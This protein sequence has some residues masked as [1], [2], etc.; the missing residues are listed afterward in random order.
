M[1]SVSIVNNLIAKARR[2]LS[3]AVSIQDEDIKEPTRLAETIRQMMLR[4]NKLEAQQ[5]P[6]A[7]E[8]ELVVGTAGALS[9]LPHNFNTAVRWWVTSWLQASGVAYPVS[10]PSLAEDS[11]STAN[12]LFLRSY[13]AGRA[14]VRVEPSQAYLDPGVIVTASPPGPASG[15]PTGTGFYHTSSGV[16]D[17]ASKKVD[18]AAAAD[19]TGTLAVG[20][21]GTG[22]TS[23]GTGVATWLGTPSSANLAAALT[24]ETGTGVAVFSTTPTFS[25]SVKLNNPGGTFA[26]TIVGGALASAQT[27]TLPLL[28]GADTFVTEAF[29][30]TLT[31]KTMSGSSNTFT[32]ISLTTAV[33]GTL[34]VANG[35]T[36]ITSFGTGVATWLGTPSGANL[37]SA[38]TT[39]LP[40]SKSTA[41]V[42]R[43]VFSSRPSAGTAGRLYMVT[44]GPLSFYDDGAAW[45]PFLA[46]AHLTST[47]AVSTL[48][49]IN[50]GG[51]STT[52]SDSLGGI[53][54]KMTNGAAADDYRLAK[55]AKPSS[56]YSFTVHMYPMLNSAINAAAGICFRTSASGNCTFFG[57]VT[58]VAGTSYL[59]IRN[60]T[61]SGTGASPTFTF[62]SDA[63]AAAICQPM[64]WG[65]GIWLRITDDGT[66]NKSFHYSHDGI[67]FVQMFSVGRTSFATPDEIG[68][69]VANIVSPSTNNGMAFFSSWVA[70]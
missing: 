8:F 50:A 43:G 64:M 18:L 26:Y 20:N 52:L 32:N 5:V 4:V 63:L 30:Q 16:M 3:Q 1:R 36:G 67:N 41:W 38:L 68:I 2:G 37:A 59:M 60:E 53:L 56:S 31:N 49:A 57:I 25:T 48:T 29:V 14:V 15:T 55:I 70:A 44:D 61:A 17:A 22:L 35:G 62:S 45:Q 23:L 66:T 51:R 28:V 9:E 34:P 21:G 65:D 40:L 6:E 7:T 11:T 69:F 12:T 10:G 47:P 27:I 54:M 39:A 13:V 24:D 58:A 42:T 19:V 33:T 46:K